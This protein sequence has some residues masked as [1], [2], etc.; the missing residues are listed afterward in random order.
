MKRRRL[1]ECLGGAVAITLIPGLSACTYTPGYV[2]PV[3][4]PYPPYYYD[5]YY[6]PH[7][8][9]YFH[10]Y[11]GYYYYR[12]GHAW[13]RTRKLPKHFYLDQRHRRKIIVPDEKP[14]TRYPKHR[15]EYPPPR[16]GRYDRDRG[17]DRGWQRDRE[18]DRDRDRD[19]REHNTRKQQE[20]LIWPKK[21]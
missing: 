7:V 19:E 13:R 11:T 18:R 15:R 1:I 12:D 4:Q 3:P 10:I 16:D 17:R 21:K 9:V 6:Y 8:G 2:A 14:Y 20:Y 5:Y